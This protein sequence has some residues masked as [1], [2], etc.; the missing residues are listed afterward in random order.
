MI[1]VE[2]YLYLII[3]KGVIDLA[4]NEKFNPVKYK[5]QFN[6]Q[7][8]DRIGL[9]VPKGKKAVI[10]QAADKEGVSLNGYINNAIDEKLK[11]SPTK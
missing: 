1:D 3:L 6:T 11:Q 4:E 9:M 10:K 7:K 2:K 5:N 8:Y